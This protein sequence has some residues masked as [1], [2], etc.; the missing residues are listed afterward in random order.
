MIRQPQNEAVKPVFSLDFLSPSPWGF[1][2]K[3][4]QNKKSY[5]IDFAQAKKRMKKFTFNKVSGLF[6]QVQK[7]NV[8]ILETGI[9][10]FPVLTK[11]TK[12]LENNSPFPLATASILLTK[13]HD[14]NS[15]IV[16]QIRST[17]NKIYSQITGTMGG[18]VEIPP[19]KTRLTFDYLIKE[20]FREAEEEMGF[21]ESDIENLHLI[22]TATDCIKP[23]KELI[24]LG[25]LQL[26]KDQV[27]Q[28]VVKIKNSEEKSLLFVDA[29][30]E[31]IETLVTQ[32]HTP[33]PPTHGVAFIAVGYYLVLQN[34]GMIQAESW[35][36]RVL[37]LAQKNYQTINSFV[38]KKAKGKKYNHRLSSYNPLLPP[39]QQG[40]PQARIDLQRIE[41][42]ARTVN[43]AWIFDVDGTISNPQEKKITEPDI[44]HTMLGK[45]KAG[46]P[47]A[48]IS[49]RDLEWIIQNV[50]RPIEEYGLKHN[51]DLL[52]NLFVS[53]EFG[54]TSLTYRYG[55]RN[56]E[57]NP[58]FSLNPVILE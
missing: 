56:I 51:S 26:T 23:H 50:V 14:G 12:P 40:L 6:S 29:K 28:R 16:L 17:H 25:L 37:G 9:A 52:H 8:L 11:S 53:G 5:N 44:I 46:Q 58:L 1:E 48:V 4:K 33:L 20:N 10:K 21:K 30:A 13:E 55:K 32:S 3:I 2:V 41:L 43:L 27:L 47:V 45:L 54:N 35:K 18:Y 15:F 38:A 42:I 22:A 39:T 7:G 19:K 36:E 49:G 24:M 34:K 57:T 31:T